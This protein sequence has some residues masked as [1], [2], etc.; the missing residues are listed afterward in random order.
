MHQVIQCVIRENAE[1]E[2]WDLV[3]QTLVIMIKFELL[4]YPF[5]P[6]QK[7]PLRDSLKSPNYCILEAVETT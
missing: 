7:L 1:L 4:Y 2:Q 5:T 6:M 3:V